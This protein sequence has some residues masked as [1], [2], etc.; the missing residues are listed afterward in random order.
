MQTHGWDSKSDTII[1]L[2]SWSKG[3]F[4]NEELIDLELLFRVYFIGLPRETEEYADQLH[5]TCKFPR[6]VLR[7][8]GG[9]CTP[10]GTI[11]C[12]S[13]P[14]TD[15]FMNQLGGPSRFG[16]LKTS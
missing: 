10:F 5:L 2:R 6:K 9:M 7:F 3:N 15:I 1:F 14:R 16:L 4:S 13:F 12:C 11:A 8:P